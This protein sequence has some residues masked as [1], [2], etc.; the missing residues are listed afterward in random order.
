LT[1]HLPIGS[2]VEQA[3]I[4]PGQALAQTI[5]VIP[6]KIAIAVIFCN[7]V[8]PAVNIINGQRIIALPET[9]GG[10]EPALILLN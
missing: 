7:N 4:E 10:R 5:H 3:V 6:Y 1:I 8:P 2:S 9:A